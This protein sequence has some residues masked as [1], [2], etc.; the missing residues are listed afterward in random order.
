MGMWAQAQM[1]QIDVRNK[2]LVALS[3]QLKNQAGS[4]SNTQKL[5]I[6]W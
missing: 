5:A 2:A 3:Q 6:N 1:S 4:Q